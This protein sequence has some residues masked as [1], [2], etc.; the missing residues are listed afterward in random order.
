MAA[1]NS[2]STTDPGGK[3]HI[4]PNDL[5][6]A[7]Y[8]DSQLVYDLLAM[9]EDG[10]SHVSTIRTSASEADSKGSGLEGGVHLGANLVAVKMSARRRRDTQV[11][12]ESEVSA[13]KVH[14][15]TSLFA[16]LRAILMGESLV[17]LLETN[18]DVSRIASGEFVEFKAILRKNPMVET[19][20]AFKQLM[21]V[22][23]AF[24]EISSS[25]ATSGKRANKHGN[26]GGHHSGRDNTVKQISALMEALTLGNSLELVADLPDS[27]AVKAVL[28][29]KSAYFNN[30]EAFEMVDGEFR[31]IGKV[32]RIVRPDVD[33]PIN[34]LRKTKFARLSN[35]VLGQMVEPIA[36]IDKEVVDLPPLA[37]SIPGPALQAI[38]IA[39]FV[40]RTVSSF[41]KSVV[42]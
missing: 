32:I 25:K 26:G 34:L 37:T 8:L 27:P 19:F 41:K 9:L 31:V 36:G 13:E 7:V 11:R 30:Q 1:G 29:A 33:E 21:E 35:T 16:K 6:V 5:P 24:Q 39:I 10:F 18:V 28:S 38:P 4:A 2:L 14:T 22:A 20:E 23:E 17:H 3:I 42:I 15:P 40:W 12:Q